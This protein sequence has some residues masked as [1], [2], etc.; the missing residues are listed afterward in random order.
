MTKRMRELQQ[1][2]Q[3]KI[4]AAMEQTQKGA[5]MDVEKT[6]SLLD[7]AEALKKEFDTLARAEQAA[8]AVVMETTKDMPV[9]ETDGF[10]IMKKVMSSQRLTD[11]EK[12][13]LITG[14]S[15]ENGENYLV[16]EDVRLEI[17]ELR[18]SYVSAKDIV[19]VTPTTELTGSE[20]YENGTPAGLTSFNDGEDLTEEADMKFARK[21]YT[22]GWHGKIIPISRILAGAE[23]AG[24]MAYIKRWFVKNAIITENA[25]I[26]GKLKSGYNSGTP[27]TLKHW[28]ELKYSINKEID[29]DCLINGLIVTNQSGFNFLDTQLDETGRPILQPDPSQPTRKMFQGLP[30][31][32]FSDKRLPNID[33][34]KYPI[35]YGDTKAGCEFVEYQNLEF[36]FSEHFGFAKNQNVMRIIE[37]FDVMSTDTEAY[38]YAVLEDE[39]A[40]STAVKVSAAKK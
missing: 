23:K 21:T 8:K 27:K 34:G 28:M 12:A 13:A 31:I 19:T 37:G 38:I 1:E 20:N 2:I 22:I 35:F 24:L 26:F 29:P 15:A 40:I 39:S 6:N 3:Q 17:R 5:D 33:E 18:R 14:T 32:I 9:K 7:E 10:S 30:I 25:A 11:T 4:D 36:A 16:P